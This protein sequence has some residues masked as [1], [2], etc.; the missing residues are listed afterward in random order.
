MEFLRTFLQFCNY[1]SRN[2]FST[3]KEFFESV[4]ALA[5][6]QAF[7]K[8]VGVKLSCSPFNHYWVK[9][10]TFGGSKLFFTDTA[11]TVQETNL[12]FV[13]IFSMFWDEKNIS[14]LRKASILPM[15]TAKVAK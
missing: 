7:L 1:P 13:G 2:K 9:I 6:Q 10:K 11:Y 8:G 15:A 5:T 4:V 12:K 14:A 3:T